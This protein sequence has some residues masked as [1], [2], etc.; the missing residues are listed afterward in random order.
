MTAPKNIRIHLTNVVGL[1]AVQLIRSLL[2]KIERASGYRVEEIYLPSKGELS[3]Y[4]TANAYTNVVKYHRFLPNSVSRFLECTI[5]AG[6]FDGT[7]P[8]LVLGDVPLRCSG[9]QTVFVQNSLLTG[10]TTA[11]GLLGK[12]KYRVLKGIFRF[13]IGFASSFI[14]QTEAM[15]SA[16]VD[17]Y[18]EIKDRIHVVPLPPPAWLVD[19]KLKRVG[20]KSD[21]KQGLRLIYPAEPYP[22]KNHILLG[23]I[24]TDDLNS[25]PVSELTLTVGADMNPNRNVPWITCA[26]RISTNDMLKKYD[27]ADALLFLS[28]TESFGFP[29]IE[30]M[31]VGLPIVCP[32]LPYARV[33]C[34]DTADY[35][36]PD[37][38]GSLNSAVVKMHE[39][40]KSGWWPDWSENLKN[41][42][43]RWQE[44]AERIL[45]ISAS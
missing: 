20:P 43:E 38:I 7:S 22:H 28:S 8:I 18:P 16:V 31:W 34:G 9:K 45:R 19:S 40:L 15:K 12:L 25:W 1:G 30:A 10:R 33:L 6:N 32:D 14:V 42:S 36:K 4:S 2:P 39:K 37:D 24:Q 29:L 41:V 44:T 23:M 17:S 35:Y 13:N 21:L 3:S 11:K 27:E 5:F 26:G